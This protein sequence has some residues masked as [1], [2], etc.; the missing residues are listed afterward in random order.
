VQTAFDETQD[1]IDVL[2]GSGIFPAAVTHLTAARSFISPA[3]HSDDGS[4]R[5]PLIQQAT[6]KLRDARNTVATTA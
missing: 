1:A 2:S 6:G 5:R 3:Q 4:Q